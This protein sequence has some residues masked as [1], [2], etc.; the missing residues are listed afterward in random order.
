MSKNGL[1]FLAVLTGAT[2]LAPIAAHAMMA[3]GTP[4]QPANADTSTRYLN[5]YFVAWQGDTLVTTLGKFTIDSGVELLDN[6]HTTGR[7][8]TANDKRPHVQIVLR[9]GQLRKVIIY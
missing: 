1:F 8:Y 2:W 4:T 3:A 9:N 7:T 5:G 6:A